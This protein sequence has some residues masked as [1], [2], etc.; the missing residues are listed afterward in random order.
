MLILYSILLTKPTY[1]TTIFNHIILPASDV[2]TTLLHLYPS[3]SPGDDGMP[4]LLLRNLA[5]Q[6]SNS[7]TYIYNKSLNDGIF[8][9]K[10]KD[11]NLIPVS[12][13]DQKDVVSNYSGIALLP[14]LYEF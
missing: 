1:L 6:I 10:W 7:I 14:I 8:P 11:C 3:R 12:K 5:P 13:S 4:S 2:L 9:S